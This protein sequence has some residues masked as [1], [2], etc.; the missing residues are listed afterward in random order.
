MRSSF[1]GVQRQALL[2]RGP[3]QERWPARQTATKQFDIQRMHGHF[4]WS[5]GQIDIQIGQ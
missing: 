3:G 4:V 5:N 2:L 1:S